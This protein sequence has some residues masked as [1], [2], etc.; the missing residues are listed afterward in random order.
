MV[1]SH[2]M[3]KLLKKDHSDIITQFNAIHVMD[4]TTQEIHSDL[5]LA[6]TNIIKSFETPKGLPLSRGDH[7]HGIPLVLGSQPPNVRPHQHPFGT[8]E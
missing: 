3:E 7:N 6:L 1:S 8:K 5:Q 4:N 2:C